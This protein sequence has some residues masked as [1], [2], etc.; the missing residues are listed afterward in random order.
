[1]SFISKRLVPAVAPVVA[2]LSVASAAAHDLHNL[3]HPS[4]TGPDAALS[5]TGPGAVDPPTRSIIVNSSKWPLGY[6]LKV[7]FYEDRSDNCGS[8]SKC[9]LTM[10]ALEAAGARDHAT[11][12][13]AEIDLWLDQPLA[14]RGSQDM[15]GLAAMLHRFP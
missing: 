15:A 13:P 3:T 9:L 6:T 2:G 8:C 11:A 12:F 1:M 7:C 10:L 5:M 14:V 4:N